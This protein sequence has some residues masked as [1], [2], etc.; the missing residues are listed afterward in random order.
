M[1]KMTRYGITENMIFEATKRDIAFGG[2]PDID[3]RGLNEMVTR[4]ALNA[5]E[6]GEKLLENPLPL[7]D[8][9][10]VGLSIAGNIYRVFGQSEKAD[11]IL[12]R[13]AEN[14]LLLAKESLAE[15]PDTKS[16]RSWDRLRHLST[17]ARIY[18]ELRDYDTAVKLSLEVIEEGKK[19]GRSSIVTEANIVGRY[20]A[21]KD[22]TELTARLVEDIN[23]H[24]RDEKDLPT[25]GISIFDGLV[26]AYWALGNNPRNL[27]ALSRESTPSLEE[28][29]WRNVITLERSI[30]D[31]TSR[32]S[33]FSIEDEVLWVVA[34]K[35]YQQGTLDKLREK[36]E[37]PEYW[38]QRI[39]E[40]ATPYQLVSDKR[41]ELSR[42]DSWGSNHPLEF[43]LSTLLL[44]GTTRLIEMLPDDIERN[45]ELRTK[46]EEI[47]A[48]SIGAST[49]Y[50]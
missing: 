44:H 47:F 13:L 21:E 16:E 50:P 28:T 7:S 23:S 15:S 33:Y 41:S 1:I 34:N 6:D 27:A 11:T 48:K 2:I 18:V 20:G 38:K 19:Q 43:Y 42:R 14:E 3:P 35:L 24:L 45:E 37:D 30:E 10:A 22:K 17:A 31:K 39:E 9:D 29:N 8:D 5:A 25:K 46:V 4:A 40:G 26:E 36:G 32:N 49:R 12:R